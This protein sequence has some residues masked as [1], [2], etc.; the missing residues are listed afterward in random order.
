MACILM[1]MLICGCVKQ[2]IEDRVESCHVA[3]QY[4]DTVNSPFDVYIYFYLVG[5]QQG[6]VESLQIIEQNGF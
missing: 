1:P 6:L 2:D 3:I 5:V 4:I